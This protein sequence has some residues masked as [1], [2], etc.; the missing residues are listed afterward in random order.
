MGHLVLF[1]E[2]KISIVC[3]A[4]GDNRVSWSSIPAREVN[5]A[6]RS[7]VLPTAKPELQSFAYEA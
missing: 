7:F 1:K 5:C 6:I 4:E 2:E 3:C